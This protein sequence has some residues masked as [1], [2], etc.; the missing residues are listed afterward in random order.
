M[1]ALVFSLWLALAAHA[2]TDG[3]LRFQYVPNEGEAP[4]ACTHKRIRDL[5]DWAVRCETPYGTK[6]FTA[7][8][9]IRQP[10]PLAIEILYWVTDPAAAP[11]GGPAFHST[12][13]YLRWKDKNAPVAASL[14]QGIENDYAS[15]TL[16]WSPSGA[17]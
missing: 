3:E 12:T 14:A 1:V 2:N 16:D 17:R 6:V 11:G 15:L 13:T 10:N 8:V 5:P 7:H 9:V 4:T